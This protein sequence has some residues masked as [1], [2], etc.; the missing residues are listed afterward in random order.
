MSQL[1]INKQ[2]KGKHDDCDESPVYELI[3]R[4]KSLA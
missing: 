1:A 2:L 3:G 4:L